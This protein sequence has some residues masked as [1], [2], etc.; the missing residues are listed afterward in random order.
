MRIESRFELLREVRSETLQRAA[1]AG[2]DAEDAADIALCVSEAVAN[3]IQHGNQGDPAKY[4][5]VN[6][7]DAP[8]Q[9]IV[10]VRDE[11]S[12]IPLDLEG[13]RFV[14]AAEGLHL[15]RGMRLILGLMDD[16]RVSHDEGRIVLVKRKRGGR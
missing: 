14:G 6:F 16:V 4:V 15:G 3:A 13:G 12:G 9:F 2:F 5:E 11:G 10:E 1:E 7:F 8:D